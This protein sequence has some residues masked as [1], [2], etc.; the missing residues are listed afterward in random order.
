MVAGCHIATEVERAI[1][2]SSLRD[3]W[4]RM[5]D[6]QQ[7]S[8]WNLVAKKATSELRKHGEKAMRA[9]KDD[10]QKKV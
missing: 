9:V 8:F 6:M 1:Q 2:N 3:C 5:S 10:F 7:D 4:N